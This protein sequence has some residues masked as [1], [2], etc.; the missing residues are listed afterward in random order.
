MLKAFQKRN[1]YLL[2]NSSIRRFGNSE[3][4]RT[5]KIRQTLTHEHKDLT[6]NIMFKEV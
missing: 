6:N 2:L 1:T 5:R 3:T 4:K